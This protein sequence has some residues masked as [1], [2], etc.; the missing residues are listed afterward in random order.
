MHTDG[1]WCTQKLIIDKSNQNRVLLNAHL[2]FAMLVTVTEFIQWE[3]EICIQFFHH[4]FSDLYSI[5]CIVSAQT[6]MR[7]D[8]AYSKDYAVSNLE[9]IFPISKMKEFN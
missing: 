8:P 2:L 6:Y 4:C 3:F 7:I 5:S 9:H 1:S